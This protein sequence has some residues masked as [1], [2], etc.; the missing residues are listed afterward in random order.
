MKI[1]LKITVFYWLNHIGGVTT[2]K[3]F[4]HYSVLGGSTDDEFMAE[5]LSF[6]EKLGDSFIRFYVTH[7]VEKMTME[8]YRAMLSMKELT[9]D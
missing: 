7:R 6:A 3:E 4:E 8:E 9:G 5:A 2:Q 1:P